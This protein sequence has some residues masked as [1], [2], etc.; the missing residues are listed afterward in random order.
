MLK[1]TK[2]KRLWSGSNTNSRSTLIVDS[3]YSTEAEM[4][5][6]F[7]GVAK[8]SA[9][10]DY[11]TSREVHALTLST[12]IEPKRRRKSSPLQDRGPH[13]RSLRACLRNVTKR[14]VSKHKEPTVIP[15]KQLAR[16]RRIF[17]RC[18]GP[19]SERASERVLSAKRNNCVRVPNRKNLSS[20]AT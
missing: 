18:S 10:G 7:S 19:T 13:D 1:K 16:N 2:K 20:S 4:I 9:L 12:W 3:H 8:Q 14:S 5:R 15:K 17:L 6:H 11:R